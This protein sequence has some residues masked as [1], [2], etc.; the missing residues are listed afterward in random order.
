MEG[1][2]LKKE[3]WRKSAQWFSLT[4][5]HAQLMVTENDVAKAFKE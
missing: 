4:A 5:Q 3:H 1:P 2:R